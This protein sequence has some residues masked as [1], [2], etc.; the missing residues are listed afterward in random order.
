MIREN[1][2]GPPLLLIERADAPGWWVRQPGSHRKIGV[3]EREQYWW[4]WHPVDQ[5]RDPKLRQRTRRQA[6]EDLAT[7][8]QSQG[9]AR[10]S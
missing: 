1:A 7:W 6:C 5:P 10:A 3:I 9:Q 4:Y 2:G 8:W